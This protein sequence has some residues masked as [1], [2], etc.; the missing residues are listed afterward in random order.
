MLEPGKSTMTIEYLGQKFVG[1]LLEDGKIKSQETETIFCSPSAW[2]MHCKRIINPEKKSGC[3]WAS[4]K[5]KGKKLDAYK[6]QWLRKCQ[7]HNK[8]STPSDGK[9]NESII[10]VL[11]TLERQNLNFQT[12]SMV[13]RIKRRW[14]RWQLWRELS[15][16][17]IRLAIEMLCSKWI[18]MVKQ[19]VNRRHWFPFYPYEYSDAN[20][21]VESVSFASLNKIQPFLVSISTSSVL[22]MDFHCHLTKTEVCGYL[23][24]SWDVNSHSERSVWFF[25]QFLLNVFA[26]L[27]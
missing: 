4:V 6:A 23:G 12:K 21:L 25:V 11:H 24:G 1:D 27:F 15:C 14:V 3:G 22:L 26:N 8:E 2:A 10:P 7:L 5:Y 13:N 16:H 9:W 19:N 18:L 20:T 17:T